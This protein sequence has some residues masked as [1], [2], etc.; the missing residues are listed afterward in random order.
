MPD[1]KAGPLQRLSLALQALRGEEPAALS[2]VPKRDLTRLTINAG[3]GSYVN[4]F[5]VPNGLATAQSGAIVTPNL[6]NA[7]SPTDIRQGG[8]EVRVKGFQQHPVVH[9]CIRAITDIG[10]AVPLYVYRDPTDMDSRVGPDHPLQA[11]LDFPTPRETALRLRSQ[12]FLNFLVYGNTFWQVLRQG[13]NGDGLPIQLKPINAEG[14]TAVW[15]DGWGD[16][17]RYDITLWNG[18]MQQLWADDVLHWKDL[19]LT[20]SGIPDVFGYPRGATA[21]ISL[22][23]DL[24]AS[25]YVRQV[26]TNDGT[27]TFAVL[28]HEKANQQD[29]QI[30]QERY[31][32]RMVER[33]KRGTPA[34]F[35]GV[36]DIKPIGFS[37]SDLEFPDLRRVSREDI[38]AAFGVDPRMV[39]IASA[40]SD[41]GLSGIQYQEARARLVQHTIEPLLHIFEDGLNAMLSP[42][43]GDVY[44]RYDREALREIVENDA[45]TSI[46]VDREFKAGLRS[47]EEART[48][49]R[50]SPVPEPTDSILQ[51]MGSQ[52]IPAAVAVIDPREVLEP[53]PSPEGQADPNEEGPDEIEEPDTDDT[54]DEAEDE[55]EDEEAERTRSS[56]AD[57]RRA[58]WET[59]NRQAEAFEPEYRQT[60]LRIFGMQSRAV[61]AQFTDLAALSPR[62]DA[63]V[64][65][66]LDDPYINEALR[67]AQAGYLPGG[68]YHRQW[69]ERYR[70]LIAKTYEVGW[71]DASV[72]LSFDL[73]SPAV[74]DAIVARADKLATYVGQTTSRQIT[75]AVRAAENAGFGIR[76]TARLIQATAFG[77]RM[78][79]ARAEL[80]ARTETLGALN[81]GSYDQAQASPGAARYK[82][83]LAFDD[84]RTRESHLEV[85]GQIVKVNEPFGNGLMFPGQQGA[86]AAEVCDCRC[87]I[88]YLD[89][90]PGAEE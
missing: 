39:G 14:V 53:A 65:V 74:Q 41:A 73:Q 51:T 35:G 47:W 17:A 58:V 63:K 62:S 29:A 20:P 28:M 56:R 31:R 69:A 66:T 71:R 26:V 45:E 34:F 9:A 78:T 27:P 19:D 3:N 22:Q 72:G 70:A 49:L 11:L 57:Q 54:E 24:E 1:G 13:K 55:A 75:A 89:A 88:A 33:G 67:R 10:A 46:R 61:A 80:I 90:L 82:E 32:E 4:Q 79:T 40:S 7:V 52:L 64:R 43:F 50:L 18:I 42:E 36:T 5:G 12:F 38:C 85:N 86:P 6:V 60:A 16:A 2:V 84:S 15:V 77:E 81:Q 76:E 48:A 8:R 87:T 25:Q 21:L 68:V 23:G 30:A 59:K 37:L 83:W 44:I